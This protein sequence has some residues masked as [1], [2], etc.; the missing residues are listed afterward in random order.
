MLNSASSIIFHTQT[1]FFVRFFFSFSRHYRCRCCSK[2]I[3]L[4]LSRRGGKKK[5]REIEIY[6][7]VILNTMEKQKQ[8]LGGG[9]TTDDDD[10]DD[11]TLWNRN[12]QNHC[13][14]A[15]WVMEEW[16]MNCVCAIIIKI[17]REKSDK[18]NIVKHKKGSIKKTQRNRILCVL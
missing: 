16:W 11:K 12:H 4:D 14:V 6:T 17:T 3:T 8:R 10:D 9:K 13:S 15:E 5:D 2:S 7:N 18:T 1:F